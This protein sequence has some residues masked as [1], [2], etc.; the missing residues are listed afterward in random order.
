M[1]LIA[2]AVNITWAVKYIKQNTFLG[3]LTF[4]NF[5]DTEKKAD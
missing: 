1:Q 5:V 3:Q 2:H 4:G